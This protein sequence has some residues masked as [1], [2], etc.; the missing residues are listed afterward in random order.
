M[1]YVPFLLWFA[2]DSACFS[3]LK[4]KKAGLSTPGKNTLYIPLSVRPPVSQLPAASLVLLLSAAF[5]LLNNVAG[6]CEQ[7]ASMLP[8]VVALPSHHS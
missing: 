1:R 5:S 4:K 2:G 8:P 6:D 3:I 7:Q